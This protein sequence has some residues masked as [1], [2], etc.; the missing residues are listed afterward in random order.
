MSAPCDNEDCD[1]CHPLPRWRISEHRIQHI[2][3]EREIKAATREEALAIFNAGTAWPSSYDDRYGEIV[4]QDAAVVVQ[5]TGEG[6]DQQA[7]IDRHKLKYYA[8]RECWNDPERL[9]EMEEFMS[10][11]GDEEFS[12]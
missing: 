9:K 6:D 1:K 2:T 7:D 3:Y 8:T 12:E 4:Q 10:R 5:I 11:G